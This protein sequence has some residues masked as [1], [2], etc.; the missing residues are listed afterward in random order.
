MTHAQLDPDR[1][2]NLAEN[3]HAGQ[4]PVLLAIGDDIGAIVLHLT[5]A[6]EAAEVGIETA[7]HEDGH[8]PVQRD[9]RYGQDHD[10]DHDHPHTHR[11]HVAVVGRPVAGGLAYTAVL[12]DLHAGRY[13]LSVP[14]QAGRLV[15]EVHGGE[16]NEVSWA[17][18]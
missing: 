5:A 2:A 11:P 18:A 15:V 17:R 1:A 4:G 12:P 7:D 13:A 10:H 16:V 6:L 3:P 8:E 14:G 9:H